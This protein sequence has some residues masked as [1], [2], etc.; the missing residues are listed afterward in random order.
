MPRKARRHCT[1]YGMK[2]KCSTWPPQR[3]IKSE[4][5]SM[6]GFGHFMDIQKNC[7][8][9]REVA[10]FVL[11]WQGSIRH[12]LP[13]TSALPLVHCFEQSQ[14]FPSLLQEHEGFS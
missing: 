13:A 7:N 10:L 3:N 9:H 12:Q 14:Y 1:Q 6:Q 4:W 8:R 5:G 2:N 11:Y